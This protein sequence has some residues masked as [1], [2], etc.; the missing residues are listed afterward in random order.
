MIGAD[1]LVLRL[2]LI[3]IILIIYLKNENN[4]FIMTSSNVWDIHQLIDYWS[5]QLELDGYEQES[6]FEAQ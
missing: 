3:Y 2:S 5:D 6:C 1:F 4:T